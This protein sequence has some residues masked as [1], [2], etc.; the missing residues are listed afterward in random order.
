MREFNFIQ[1]KSVDEVLELLNIY[2]SKAKVVAGGTD[3][4]VELRKDEGPKDLEVVINIAHLDDLNYIKDDGEWVR[5]GAATPHAKVVKSGLIQKE[6]PALAYAAN[7]VGSPQI[8]N[9]GTIGGNIMNASPAADTVPV[10]VALDAVLTFRSVSGKRRVPI[11][12][13]YVKPYKTNVPPEELLV[14]VSFKKLPAT[15]SSAFIKLG[16]RNALAIS[17]MNVAVILDR[18]AEGVIKD[19]RIAPGSTTPVPSRIKCA[20]EVLLGKKPTDEL[21]ELAGS[22]V[23][24]EMIRISGYRWSTEYKKPV[25]EALTR[26]GIRK[27]LGGQQ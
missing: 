5:I 1:P 20:E 22:K 9:R 10:L 8:R 18:D 21:I 27:A 25:I 14:E 26:R 6:I 17:R 23:S 4:I 3:L 15:A 11:T 19:I 13:I 2:G 24:E 7:S 16:R 12:D